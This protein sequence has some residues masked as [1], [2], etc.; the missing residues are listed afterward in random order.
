MEVHKSSLL[1]VFDAK[2]RLEVPL[3]Q[4]QYVWNEE[5]HWQPLWED[6]GRKF[7]EALEGRKDAPHHFLGAMVLDQKQ[8]PTGHVVLRQVIDGQQRL[9]TLQIFL[10]AYRDFCKQN[11]CE[12]L[13]AECDKFLFNTGMMADPTIDKFKVWPTQLDRGQFVDVISAGSHEE[14]LKRYPLRR[15]P[16][17]RKPDPRPRM[18]EAYLFL[19]D[20]VQEFFL[21]DGDEPP[22]AAEFTLADRV[23]ECFQTLRNS[24]MVVIIDLQKDDDPQVIFETLNARGEPLL[25]A[26]LLRNYIFLRAS[27]DLPDIETI[28]NK[29]WSGFDDEFWR[30][31][32]KQG[33][34][35]RPRSDLFMQH[36]LASR[37][38]QDIPIKHLYVEYRHW[39]ESAKPFPNVTTELE[40]L[41]R[42]RDHFRRII[43]PAEGDP[44]FE[45][46]SFLE[47]YDIRTAYPLLLA[48]LDAGLDNAQWN[49]VSA[50]LESYLVRRAVCNLT[51]KNYNR[52]FLSVTKALQRDGLSPAQLRAT[53]LG[54]AGDSTVWPDDATF[55]ES[56]LHQRVYNTL[57]S[58]RLVHL[59]RRLNQTYMSSK[60]EAFAFTSPP[61]IEHIM[62]QSWQENWA[63]PDKSNG[64]TLAELL[65]ATD[66][67][68]RAIA[69]RKRDAT[70]QTMGNLTILSTGLNAAQSNLAWA[71][72]RPEMMKHS[73]LPINQSLLETSEWDEKSIAHR[74]L[75]LFDRAAQIW[76][77]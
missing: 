76:K 7:T 28:Y 25:P 54:Q 65:E 72:K 34:L 67:D 2:Q 69:T 12:A 55:R 27:R 24:L 23:D 45:L 53:L 4:R 51:T 18:V 11:D 26:D 38:G 42:Q 44:I 5:R 74:G 57:N 8:T 70:I 58:A 43:A 48:L 31:E 49:E 37:Q 50:I 60:S 56:W 59:L 35:T 63:L 47:S 6:I 30:E 15:R 41:A 64:M 77:R 22:I 3:F 62:P 66:N 29:Y 52:I 1:A 10:A 20:Q 21:G 17:A 75:E 71:K 13:A 32:V 16:Y 19:F 61:T 73:L 36:F 46:C 68:P 14:V 40:T 9:T 39:L 33:R